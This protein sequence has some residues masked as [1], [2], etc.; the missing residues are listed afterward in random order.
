MRGRMK[1]RPEIEEIVF[2]AFLAAALVLL[3]SLFFCQRV[4]AQEYSLTEAELARLETI[5]ANLRQKQQ[6]AQYKA[7]TLQR[8]LSYWE[9]KAQDLSA[10]L[11]SSQET[12]TSLRQSFA[13]YEDEAQATLEKQKQETEKVQRRAKSRLI[14]L[15]VENGIFLLMAGIYVLVRRLH[16]G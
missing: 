16:P 15:I 7:Q 6:E 4:Q 1:R 11:S 13:K 3:C 14:I 5:S 2:R 10:S 8:D 9:K 12:L